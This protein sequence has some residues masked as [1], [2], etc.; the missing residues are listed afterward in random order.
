MIADPGLSLPDVQWLLGHALITTTQIYTE[1]S[2]D[3]AVQR[4]RTHH[5]AQ[6]K[7][8]PPAAPA[9]G[10]RPEVLATLLGTSPSALVSTV[11]IASRFGA[12][13]GA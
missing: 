6:A 9:P 5:A 7:P 4:V 1:P 11:G 12:L 8:R 2:A 10:Y 13:A 3:E